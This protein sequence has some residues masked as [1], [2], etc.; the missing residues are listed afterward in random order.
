M[1][2]VLNTAVLKSYSIMTLIK[3]VIHQDFVLR[4]HYEY[5]WHIFPSWWV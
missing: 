2:S 5:A 4:V 1:L 3:S